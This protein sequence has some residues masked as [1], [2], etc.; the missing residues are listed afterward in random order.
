[1]SQDQTKDHSDS[2]SASSIRSAVA[3]LTLI[4]ISDTLTFLSDSFIRS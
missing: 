4:F 1:M 3:L 2:R